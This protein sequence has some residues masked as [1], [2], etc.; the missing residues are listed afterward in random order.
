MPPSVAPSETGILLGAR[1]ENN[2]S[3]IDA[4]KSRLLNGVTGGVSVGSF[5]R[6]A[7]FFL[8]GTGF[9]QM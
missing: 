3:A 7:H 6:H 9:P 5:F 8:P 4:T 1:N 2:V